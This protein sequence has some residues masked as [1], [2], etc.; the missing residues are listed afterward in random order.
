MSEATERVDFERHC[1][2]ALAHLQRG[3]V[4]AA[5]TETFFGLLADATSKSALD[6]LFALKPREAGKAIGLLLPDRDGWLQVV[7]GVSPLAQALAD[8]FWPG[9]LTLVLPAA[10]NLD[11]R[12]V[13]EAG[14]GVRLAGG[15]DAALLAQRFGRPLTATSANPPGQP[16]A[17]LAS[18][19]E[20]AFS[21]QIAGGQLLV[22]PGR[23]PGGAAST[24]VTVRDGGVQIV[25]AGAIAARD[26]DR[27]ASAHK[28]QSKRP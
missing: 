23:S 7:Q 16:P 21:A 6:A 1:A 17:G 19:V 28:P 11:S 2:V 8:E 18:E 27:V 20:Q 15:S 25:R 14:I 24:V 9:P 12:L 4:V 22:L 10:A 26:I 13:S 3:G 5:A